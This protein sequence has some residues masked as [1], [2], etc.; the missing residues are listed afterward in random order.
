MKQRSLP[1]DTKLD[2]SSL[3]SL[4]D[5][6]IN[7]QHFLSNSQLF[8]AQKLYIRP[9]LVRRATVSDIH[10]LDNNINDSRVEATTTTAKNSSDVLFNIFPKNPKLDFSTRYASLVAILLYLEKNYDD[11]SNKILYDEL[12]QIQTQFTNEIL[13]PSMVDSNVFQTVNPDGNKRYRTGLIVDINSSDSINAPK[14]FSKQISW[15]NVKIVIR[16]FRKKYQRYHQLVK[17]DQKNINN[18]LNI[19]D[20]LKHFDETSKRRIKKYAKHYA[21][22]L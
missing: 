10:C 20:Y 17:Y 5:E 7:Y 14:L 18:Q 13:K 9:W 22:K 15:K 16:R 2:S 3:S 11:N 19:E 21:E 4:N 12:D 1:V 8:S 6:P